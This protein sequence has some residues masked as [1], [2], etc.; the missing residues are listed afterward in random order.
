MGEGW[1]PSL[2]AVP[3]RAISMSVRQIMKSR[4]LVV[5][6]PDARKADAVRD[7]VEGPVTPDHPASILQ[8]HPACHLFLDPASASKLGRTG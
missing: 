6:V 5:S 8:R 4:L 7:A 2:D 3:A 1:F